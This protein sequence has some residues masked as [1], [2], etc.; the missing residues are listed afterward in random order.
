M[1]QYRKSV[2]SI[3]KIAVTAVLLYVVF[4]KV[5]FSDIGELM[6]KAEVAYLIIAAAGFVASQWV[7]AR[8]LLSFFHAEGFMVKPSE[9]LRLYFIGMFY[10]FFIPGGV[11]GDAYK[12]YALHKAHR[13]PVKRLSAAVLLDRASGLSAILVLA[14][15]LGIVLING[16]IALLIALA[17]IALVGGYFIAFR[18]FFRLYYKIAFQALLL[19]L[20]VQVLQLICVFFILKSLS[21]VGDFLIY[22]MMFLLSS[23]LS[24]ISFS[25]IGV[26]EWLFM[27]AAR[28]FNFDAGISVA[29][30]LLFS[31]ITMLVSLAGLYSLTFHNKKKAESV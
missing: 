2:V 28:Y 13:W 24:L 5:P 22:F 1:K 29:V 27:Y 10:N 19:S 20:M 21:A 25:G 12:V 17:V 18:L 23:V 4:R 14:G 9:N 3:L 11:G 8:R 30:A 6:K 16:R 26:R 15:V 31:L 7:S